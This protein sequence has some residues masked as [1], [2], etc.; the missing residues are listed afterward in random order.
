VIPEEGTS[1]T[2]LLDESRVNNMSANYFAPLMD[3]DDIME[4]SMDMSF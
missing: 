4:A 2:D 1:N 3:T